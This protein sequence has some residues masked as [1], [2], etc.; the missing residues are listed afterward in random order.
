MAHPAYADFQGI[1][2]RLMLK[3]TA[4]Q[5]KFYLLEHP[6]RQTMYHRLQQFSASKV[7]ASAMQLHAKACHVCRVWHIPSV[8]HKKQCR[9]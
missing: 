1:E 7:Y 8:M 9:S 2:L 5:P 3:I 6:F 4:A